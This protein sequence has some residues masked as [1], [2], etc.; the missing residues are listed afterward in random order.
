[1]SLKFL[2]KPFPIATALCV[3]AAAYLAGP[4]RN[5]MSASAAIAMFLHLSLGLLLTIPVALRLFRAMRSQIARRQNAWR[6]ALLALFAAAASGISLICMA[7]IGR[8]TAHA[9]AVTTLHSAAGALTVIACALGW[10]LNRPRTSATPPGDAPR[11]A[12]PMLPALLLLGT[13]GA[14]FGAAALPIYEPESYYRDL[15]ATNSG[16]AQN[17][18]FPAGIRFA[19]GE[20][21]GMSGPLPASAE[22]GAAGCHPHEFH[23][24]R[25]SVHRHAAE[26]PFYSATA[27]QVAVRSGLEAVR[28]CSGCHAPG[29]AVAAGSGKTK[30][31]AGNAEGVGCYACH[32][33]ASVPGRTGNGRYV[34]AAPQDYPFAGDTGL[35]GQLHD[36]L[37]RL[38]PGP[39]QRLLSPPELQR[40][41]EACSA[42]HRQSLTIA[43]NRYQVVKG[44]DEYGEWMRGPVAGRSARASR[45]EPA[46]DRQCQDCHAPPIGGRASHRMAGA[47]TTLSAFYQDVETLQ[48]QRK[49]IARTVSIDLL[50]LRKEGGPNRGETWIA[51]IDAPQSPYR[52]V[53]GETWTLEAVLHNRAAGHAFPA[54]YPDLSQAWLELT[55][56][57]GEGRKL[58]QNGV[59]E[60]QRLQRDGADAEP[61]SDAHQYSALTLDRSGEPIM[62]HN[63]TEQ[64][65]T[66]YHR[67]IPPG[68]SDIARYRF[69]L[70]KPSGKTPTLRITCRLRYRSLR[71]DFVRWALGSKE[72]TGSAPIT[73]AETRIDIPLETSGSRPPL[74][75]QEAERVALRFSRYGDALLAPL[76][77]PDI[78][79]AIRAFTTAS[80]L[81]PGLADPLLGLGA[82]F[83]REPDL[84]LAGSYFEQALKHPGGHDAGLAYLGVVYNRQGQP[85]RA[86]AA[87]ESLAPRYPQDP[88]LML[89]LGLAQFRAGKYEDAVRSFNQSL[90]ADPESYAAHFGLKRCYEVL[91]RNSEA[92]REDSIVRYL[93]EDRLHPAL[94]E[95]LLQRRPELTMLTQAL[96]VHVLKPPAPPPGGAN[97]R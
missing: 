11:S 47:S 39:H 4:A 28:W 77:K 83:L 66:A 37:L 76:D 51:P 59:D 2:H 29:E 25:E 30:P 90:A 94:T 19:G 9:G 64:V 92:R 85:A 21:A 96:P 86:V 93:G 41:S 22:C 58:L 72:M 13:Q 44:P 84:R 33:M 17:R 52:L 38:R 36:F 14:L 26:D 87:L 12:L 48:A 23:E 15:T 95:R 27:R 10:A 68:G 69:T 45:R 3:G 43:Q 60:R 65:T 6:L 91:R 18:L 46:S 40:S 35:R 54:G 63:V 82:A 79:R 78:G 55:V 80:V 53:P 32:G 34:L 61:P 75:K 62:T 8:S 20:E 88:E 67:A 31:P 89:D 49:L 1:M 5:S 71:P 74:P 50:V 70:P 16:Q 57:D 81:A 73:A 24:W 56:S 97:S 7:A 42:C